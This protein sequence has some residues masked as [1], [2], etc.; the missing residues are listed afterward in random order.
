VRPPCTDSARR[1][2]KAGQLSCI[3]PPCPQE[4]L[5]CYNIGIPIEQRER[6]MN[7]AAARLVGLAM[8]PKQPD[9]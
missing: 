5:A 4:L 2:P 1:Q 7:K 8:P 6:D 9:Y 3:D